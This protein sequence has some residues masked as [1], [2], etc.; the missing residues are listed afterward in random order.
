[1]T[2]ATINTAATVAAIAIVVAVDIFTVVS[3]DGGGTEKRDIQHALL[4]RTHADNTPSTTQ[5][6]E[7]H[8]TTSVAG[9]ERE[10]VGRKANNV[11]GGVVSTQHEQRRR[12]SCRHCCL[13]LH[14]VN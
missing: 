9:D 8:D 11:D 14:V 1:M 7:F 3:D 13:M 5:T 2:N 10:P 12:L 4:V 6:P